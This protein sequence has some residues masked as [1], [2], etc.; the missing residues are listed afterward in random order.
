MQRECYD[1]LREFA[2]SQ[3]NAPKAKKK[4]VKLVTFGE[5]FDTWMKQEKEPNC[6]EGTLRNFRSCHKHLKA[7]DPKPLK[8]ITADDIRQLLLAS[9]SP[10]VRDKCYKMLA[11]I[12]RAAVQYDLVTANI[13]DKVSRFKTP[14]AHPQRASPAAK[15]TSSPNSNSAPSEG[16]PKP[17]GT[18]CCRASRFFL[19][20]PQ[21]ASPAAKAAAP[22]NSTL[23]VRD[24]A[25]V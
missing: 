16:A 17:K 20:H 8:K 3:S 13:M 18:T 11:M 1:N 25:A 6:R 9:P 12:F 10:E 4:G 14:K 24:S 23:R 5:F 22:P 7:L 19:S 21:R 15:A 2:N